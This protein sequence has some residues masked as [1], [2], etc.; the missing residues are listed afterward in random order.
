MTKPLLPKFGSTAGD[1]AISLFGSGFGQ[2]GQDFV[3]DVYFGSVDVPSSNS[4]PAR[5]RRPV[6]SSWWAPDSW[7]STLPRIR[8]AQS[9]SR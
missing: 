9:M 1:E 8:P 2:A 4:Y 5:L 3:S 6:V 7:P